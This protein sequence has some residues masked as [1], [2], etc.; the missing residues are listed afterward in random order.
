[1]CRLKR[2][3]A[4]HRSQL[5]LV[6]A[7]DYTLAAKALTLRQFDAAAT[8]KLTGFATVDD[9]Y[10]AASSSNFIPHIR[11]P[12]LMLTSKDDPFLGELPIQQCRENEHTIL[13]VTTAG[14]HCAHLQGLLPLGPTWSDAAIMEF[15]LAVNGSRLAQR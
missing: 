9:Y 3:A 13:A 1:M 12:T 5:E 11:T 7:I 2:Y 8:C 4:R 15:I 6:S 10:R 14:G